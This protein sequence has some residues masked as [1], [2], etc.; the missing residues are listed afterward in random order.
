MK[1]S[2]VIPAYNEEHYIGDCIDAVKKHAGDKIHEIIV[3]NNRS[4]DRTE[5]IAIQK[6]ARVVYEA[7]KGLTRARQRGLIEATGDLLAYIDADTRM[8]RGWV[9]KAETLYAKYPDMVCLSGPYRYYDGSVWKRTVMNILWYVTAP[10]PYRLIG[11]MTLGGNFIAKKEALTAMGGFDTSIDFYGED[12]DIARRLS[13]FGKVRFRMDFFIYSSSRRFTSEGLI[14]TNIVYAL[15]FIW[16]VLFH[17]PF[18]KRY[19]DIRI[20]NTSHTK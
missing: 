1:I 15:N 8:P 13:S 12:T 4:T 14:K 17:R 19:Q 7:L 2:I 9:E 20:K 3:I 5:E 11:Y 16:E 10:I 6:G 18:T